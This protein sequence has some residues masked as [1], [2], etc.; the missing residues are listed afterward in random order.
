MWLRSTENIL[1]EAKEF[2]GQLTQLLL[3]HSTKRAQAAEICPCD[4]SFVT[5]LTRVQTPYLFVLKKWHP[6]FGARFN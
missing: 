3:V 1:K 5:L 6:N 4:N 2:F